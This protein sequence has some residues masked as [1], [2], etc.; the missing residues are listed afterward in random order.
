[1]QEFEVEAS[2]Y[3]DEMTEVTLVLKSDDA[4]RAVWPH[5][6]RLELKVSVSMK[7]N[8]TM[9]ATNMGK[10]PFGFSCG[11]HPYILLRERDGATVKGLDGLSFFNGVAGKDDKQTGD[12]VMDH[13]TDHIFTLP[14]SP[15]HE[16][17]VIDSGLRRAVAI[18]SSGNDR[19]VVWNPGTEYTLPDFDEDSWRRFVCVE[20]VSDWPDG[21]TLEPGGKYVLAAAI[22]STMETT[23][24]T[25]Q[26]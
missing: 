19:V 6:F 14:S 25:A 22:Q 3:S 9:T 13:S 15:R 12:L 8:L 18:A 10:E 2:E 5:D 24:E 23:D 1:M 26:A 16:F 20:P 11:F 4:T 17:A 21:R 7:L